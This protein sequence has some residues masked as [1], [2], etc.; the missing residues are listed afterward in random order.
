[1]V[2]KS[3]PDPEIFLKAAQ[4]LDADPEDTY[5]IED[6]FNGIRAAHAG[7]FI[8]VMVPDMLPPDDEMR[9]KANYIVDTLKEVAG[10]L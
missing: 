5:I 3:K 2:T 10:I 8:S 6:S 4:L 7:G 1:M 9:A